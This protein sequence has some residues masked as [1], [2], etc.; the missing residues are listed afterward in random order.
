[1]S[2]LLPG[3]Y[4][5]FWALPEPDV[6]VIPA[7][8]FGLCSPDHLGVVISSYL[9]LQP[10][11]GPSNLVAGQCEP[12]KEAESPERL[13]P[14]CLYQLEAWFPACAWKYLANLFTLAFVWVLWT[15]QVLQNN[16]RQ[17]KKNPVLISPWVKW[18]VGLINRILVIYKAQLPIRGMQPQSTPPQ[19]Y[20]ASTGGGKMN[21]DMVRAPLGIWFYLKWRLD[22]IKESSEVMYYNEGPT[23]CLENAVSWLEPSQP[24]AYIINKFHTFF[25][26]CLQRSEHALYILLEYRRANCSCVCVV[27]TASP[28]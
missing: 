17:H 25:F 5:R 28:W 19:R 21:N 13:P 8:V 14:V 20:M 9:G 7:P 6:D 11:P 10:W 27:V 18:Q 2:W 23:G 3:F 1:M 15:Q 22:S 12:D 4:L 26:Y 16:L 24:S